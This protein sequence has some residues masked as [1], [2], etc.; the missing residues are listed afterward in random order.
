MVSFSRLYL[1]QDCCIELNDTFVE[2]I[3]C[4]SRA[5]TTESDGRKTFLKKKLFK[6]SSSDFGVTFRNTNLKF[7]RL[8][9][10]KTLIYQI[11]SHNSKNALNVPDGGRIYN[12]LLF[13]FFL[14]LILNQHH[15]RSGARCSILSHHECETL[16]IKRRP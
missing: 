14:L 12:R 7:T 16:S 6:A 3:Y 15:Y 10:R 11:S 8:L 5:A 4:K 2:P 13:F 9:W 1:L